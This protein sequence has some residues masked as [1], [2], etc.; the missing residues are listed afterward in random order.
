MLK[1]HAALLH[2]SLSDLVTPGGFTT[3]PHFNGP[4]VLTTSTDKANRFARNCSCNSTLD[5][6]S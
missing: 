2:F 4:R 6:G 3:A 1:Q 5:D